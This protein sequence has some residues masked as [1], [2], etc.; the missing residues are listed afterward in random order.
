MVLVSLTPP[1]ILT[2]LSTF[3]KGEDPSAIGLKS[4]TSGKVTGNSYTPS[5]I[6]FLKLI[7]KGSPQYLC[8]ENP[9]SLNL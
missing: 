4:S 8:L 3:A 6:S 2:Q 9:A 1:S 5:G 7:G